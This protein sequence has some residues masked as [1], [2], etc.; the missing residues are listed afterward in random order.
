MPLHRCFSSLGCPEFSLD[1]V[2][3]LADKHRVPQ[4]ELRALGG[5][6]D[7]GTYLAAEYGTPGNLGAA[8]VPAV[9]VSALDASLRLIDGAVAER[10]QLAA[11]APW[12]DAMGV[13]WLRV[14]DGGNHLDSAAFA[15]AR[16]T[17][18]WWRELR[19]RHGWKS[20]L[21]VETHDSLLTADA[22][23]RFVDAVPDVGI[24]WDAHHTWR[25]GGEDPALTWTAIRPYVVH[26]HVKD[27]ISVPSSRHPFTYVVPG[28]GEFPMRDVW[29]V[30]KTDDFGGAVSLEWE[31][32]WHP[33]LPSLDEALT[34]ATE[35]KWW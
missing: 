28:D 16:K 33:Y 2:L 3:A 10:E 35:R 21:M 20:D 30:L 27:S 7:L 12:A 8:R 26:V 6:L 22:I 25:K 15:A 9:R 23:R 31:K 1:G 32:L 11:L 29:R 5:T 14:F 17:L 18:A 34:A 13:R 4:V 19:N 24:L